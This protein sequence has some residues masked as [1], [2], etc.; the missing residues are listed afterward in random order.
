MFTNRFKLTALIIV[1]LGPCRWTGK[2]QPGA[3]S[4]GWKARITTSQFE[5]E[6]RRRDKPA[7]GRMFVVG[8]V[9]DPQGKPVPNASV[10]VYARFTALQLDTPAGGLYVKEI[11]HV[12]G[13]GQG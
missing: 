6:G 11:G 9:L 12:P 7:P 4:G 1:L 2:L 5:G 10:M 13:D 8:R 3:G